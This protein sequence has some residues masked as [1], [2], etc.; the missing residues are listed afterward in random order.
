LDFVSLY[1]A[2]FW[3]ELRVVELSNSRGGAKLQTRFVK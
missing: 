2:A 1:A 3:R